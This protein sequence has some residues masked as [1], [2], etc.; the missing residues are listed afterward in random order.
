[1]RACRSR[2]FSLPPTVGT[3][4]VSTFEPVDQL[5]TAV[6]GQGV[7]PLRPIG[8]ADRSRACVC[9][10]PAAAARS[11]G[12][13]VERLGVR[14]HPRRRS[15]RRRCGSNDGRCCSWRSRVSR[16]TGV[17]EGLSIDGAVQPAPP[18]RR[19]R[20]R[21]A[22]GR[23]GSDCLLRGVVVFAGAIGA[24]SANAPLFFFPGAVTPPAP[25]L[26][27]RCAPPVSIPGAGGRALF[28]YAF[29]LFLR[30]GGVGGGR[31]GGFCFF[32]PSFFVWSLGTP[33]P[34]PPFSP[35]PFLRRFPVEGFGVFG[36]AAFPVAGAVL[37][38]GGGGGGGGG[39]GRRPQLFV[40]FF[41]FLAMTPGFAN[42]EPACI[43]HPMSSTSSCSTRL[44]FSRAETAGAR[45]P[46]Q[47]PGSGGAHRHAA[48]GVHPRRPIGGRADGS[49]PAVARPRR[50]DGRRAG[51]DRR[52]A[53]GRHVSRT[54]RSS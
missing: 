48:A 46:A 49:R 44:E 54:A 24:S 47:L 16:H 20:R 39:G 13:G 43:S 1:M 27:A 11:T 8:I 30:A 28:P 23:A 51:D 3:R 7:S 29:F 36:G 21:A 40:F 32:F 35:S 42:G 17:H 6:P 5:P 2:D 34:P 19:R 25:W 9:D 50:G 52:G 41:L 31:G 38:L 33:G 12:L 45:S 37:R 18:R 4:L 15:G 26:F 14:V 22:G 53:G 10:E